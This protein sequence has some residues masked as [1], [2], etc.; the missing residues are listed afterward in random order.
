MRI[1]FLFVLCVIGV[2]GG[3]ILAASPSL[4]GIQPRGAQRGT[5]AVVTFSGGRLADAQEV[6]VYYPGITVK[7]L[8]V[9]NDA[10]AEGRRSNIAADCRL[11]EH[12]FRVRTATGVSELRTF[13]VGA[14]PVVERG[15]PNS[16]FDKPQPIALNVTVHGVVQSRGRRL[17]RRR[18]QEGA[19]AV[20]RS[21]RRCGSAITFFDPYVAILDSKRFELATGDDSPLSGQDGGCSVVIPADGK[22]I[23]QVR[24]SAYGGNGAC[25]YRLH[26]GNFPRPTAVVPAGGK[27]GEE[28]EV[29]FLGDPPGRSSRRS[30]CPPTTRTGSGGCTAR[31]RTALSPTGFK[32]RVGDLPERHRD[33]HERQRR[34]RR[35]PAPRPARSTA[36]SPS[37]ARSTTSSSPP[38]RGRRSTS[39]ATPAGSARRS[40]R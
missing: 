29:T 5:E 12:A 26:V 27:P 3:E 30:S 9:V 14:L 2:L 40:T 20:G 23:V 1:R 11:G 31:R 15:E 7:K 39:T 19:A 6:L 34:R 4:G 13:W 33:R 35:R 10:T 32:F 17:L 8:E 16:E 24:E 18:V 36:S 38:R 37:P 21:R 25:Q 28:V 22:Y